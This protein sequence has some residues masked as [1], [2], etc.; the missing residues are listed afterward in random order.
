MLSDGAE[1]GSDFAM[2]PERMRHAAAS[3]ALLVWVTGCVAPVA[4]RVALS[5]PPV[6]LA[7][8]E[9]VQSVKVEVRGGRVISIH[10]LLDDWDAALTWDT[11][12][13]LRVDLQA[14]HFSAGLPDLA[15]LNRFLILEPT[16]PARPGIKATIRMESTEPAG[17][18]DRELTLSE[19]DLVLIPVGGPSR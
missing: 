3:L 10:R 17:R 13:L 2:R 5:F 16:G 8:G 4:H 9:Y 6:A 7:T 14:R 19:S 12:D 18:P 15:R 11:P 1:A